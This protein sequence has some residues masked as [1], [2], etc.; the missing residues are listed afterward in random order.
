MRSSNSPSVLGLVIIR[1]AICGP[2]SA[3]TWRSAARSML[4]RASD[5]SSITSSPAMVTVAGLVPWAELGISTWL[6]PASPRAW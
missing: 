1:P 5:G 3:T 6:R 2:R 4:P